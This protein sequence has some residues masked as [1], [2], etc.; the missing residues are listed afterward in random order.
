[1]ASEPIRTLIIDDDPAD[2]AIFRQYLQ[3]SGSAAFVFR[4]EAS[5]AAGMQAC[6]EFK[7]DCVLLDYSLPDIDGLSSSPATEESRRAT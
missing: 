2:R 6:E 4:E 3:F 5:G 7:P 1:M